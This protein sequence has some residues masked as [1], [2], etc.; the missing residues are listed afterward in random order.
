MSVCKWIPRLRNINKEGARSEENPEPAEPQ[1][2]ADVELKEV[3]I[4]CKG[5]A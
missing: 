2:A 5:G 3:N 1:K 4:E